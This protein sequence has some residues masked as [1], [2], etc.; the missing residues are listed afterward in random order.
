MSGEPVEQRSDLPELTVEATESVVIQLFY[1]DINVPQGLFSESNHWERFSNV[2]N[3]T[4]RPLAASCQTCTYRV[5][6]RSS[7]STL[8]V[9]GHVASTVVEGRLS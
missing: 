4:L 8:C 1:A 5:R 6:L 9:Q 3:V 2:T 7:R